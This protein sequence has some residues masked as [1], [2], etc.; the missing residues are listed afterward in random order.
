[1]TMAGRRWLLHPFLAGLYFVLTLAASNAIA[2]HGL[3]DLVWPISISLL[4]GGLCWTVGYALTRDARKASLLSLL[5]V[6]AIS[7]FGYVV[8]ALRPAGALNL[9]GGELGLSGLFAIALF[10]PSLA[11]HRTVR[12]LDALS[13][14]LT[15][16]GI[17]LV[18]FTTVQLYQGLRQERDLRALVPPPSVPNDRA[19]SGDLPNIYLII[20]DKYTGTEVLSQNFGF[21]NSEFEA[22]LRDRGF[23]VP[24]HS[25]A[26]YP[27]TQLALASMLNLDYIHNLPPQFHLY[28]LIENNRLAGFLKL[29]GYRFVFFPTPFKFTHQNRNADLQLPSP[30][31]VRGE[32]GAVWQQTTMLP[33]LLSAGCALLGCQADRLRYAAETA[34]FMDWKFERLKDL[35]GGEVPTFALAHLSLPHEPYLYHADCTHRAPYW[36]LAA[37]M[38]GDEEATKGYLDQISCANRKVAAL[39]DSILTRSRHPPVI[40]IQAD[41]GHGRLGRLPEYGK[42]NAYQLRE[43]MSVFSAYLLPGMG[44]GVVGDSITPV[45]AM[46][47]VLRHY[48]GADLPPMEDASYWS[49][50]EVPFEFVRIE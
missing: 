47:L 41:H 11:I 35:S 13:R 1:M 4:V 45:S 33:E 39:I 36:P 5:W 44:A 24:K 38:L 30:K 6:I 32:F 29:Q 28:D 42:L 18:G 17:L 37:G 16:V 19:K 21:D 31:E 43:R 46:R 20:L 7:V 15:L 34:D 23:V 14:Y 2:L 22:F 48:F 26:N 40:L 10:G 3:R 25:R 9:L 50:E 49:T 12:N 27:Q 8:D